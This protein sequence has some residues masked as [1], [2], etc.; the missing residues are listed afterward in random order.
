V[1]VLLATLGQLQGQKGSYNDVP[2]AVQLI[3]QHVDQGQ[4]RHRA[5]ACTYGDAESMHLFL[6]F[7]A[8]LT[9]V[10]WPNMTN[11]S[12]LHRLDRHAA[13]IHSAS[14]ADSV[15]FQCCSTREWL[16]IGQQ[17]P[18]VAVY[19]MELLAWGSTWILT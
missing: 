12:K 13:L 8:P 10:Y 6:N 16:A 3:Q 14:Q 18:A 17:A 11:S 7:I 1:D 9:Q 5:A 2:L 15:S 4:A 19:P